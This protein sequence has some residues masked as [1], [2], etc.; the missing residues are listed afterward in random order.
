MAVL[1]ILLVAIAVTALAGCGGDD[2]STTAAATAAKVDIVNFRFKPKTI[3]IEAGGKVTWLNSDVA[4]HT[5]TADDRKQFDTRTL[6]T[7]QSATVVFR[8]P[9]TISYLCLFHPFMVGKV[10]VVD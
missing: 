3:T 7:G 5:A 9:G 6:R 1:P 10:E 2:E 8:S 4:P